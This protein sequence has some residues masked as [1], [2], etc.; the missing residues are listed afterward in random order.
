MLSACTSVKPLRYFPQFLL[1]KLA[2]HGLDECTVLKVKNH[3]DIWAQRVLVNGV[4]FSWW[5]VTTGFH[6]GKRWNSEKMLLLSSY[7][8]FNVIKWERD[9]LG[10]AIHWTLAK[11]VLLHSNTW[12]LRE[13]KNEAQGVS[14]LT[15]WPGFTSLRSHLK[16]LPTFVGSLKNMH[17]GPAPIW[18]V[19][20]LLF[21][22]RYYSM[23]ESL[24]KAEDGEYL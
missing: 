17:S 22:P 4:T 13:V 9:N 7:H 18:R 14:S 10:A 12:P 23:L 3:L 1:E 2:A 6:Q 15:S 19:H 20:E 21:L 16:V 8:K 24:P 11:V 5:P